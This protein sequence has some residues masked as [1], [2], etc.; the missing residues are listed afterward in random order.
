MNMGF[1]QR[2]MERAFVN[3][4]NRSLAAKF[5]CKTC[6]KEIIPFGVN[7]VGQQSNPPWCEFCKKAVEDV[8]KKKKK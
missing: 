8:Y 1:R 6:G 7:L 3:I 5:N 2:L 4:T